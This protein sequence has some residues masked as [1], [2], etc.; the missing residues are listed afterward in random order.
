M[1]PGE[2][3]I[4]SWI[5]IHLRGLN[6]L[7]P[8]FLQPPDDIVL[9][10]FFALIDPHLTLQFKGKFHEALTGCG[11]DISINNYLFINSHAFIQ[12]IS[13]IEFGSIA[14][15]HAG[16]A[17]AIKQPVFAKQEWSAAY[18]RDLCLSHTQG[19][20]EISKSFVFIQR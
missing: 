7:Y 16:V 12:N 15:P 5:L 14:T 8:F 2:F 3:Q 9:F 19:L 10:F 20:Q 11:N 6:C 1:K 13:R 4:P 17:F 18:C